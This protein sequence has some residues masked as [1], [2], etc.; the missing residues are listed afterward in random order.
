VF[1][2]LSTSVFMAEL[3]QGSLNDHRGLIWSAYPGGGS[4]VT[5]FAPNGFKD[6]YGSDIKADVVTNA[7]YGMDEPQF[8]LPLTVIP[9]PDSIAFS[10]ARS[11]HPGGLNALFG[12]GSVRF[13]KNSIDPAIWIAINSISSG[14]VIS[15]DSY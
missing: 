14:E 6:Y 8:G 13:V 5:R 11:R 9:G 1:D 4:Y 15:S 7:D 10:G 12:D 3:I 2:G